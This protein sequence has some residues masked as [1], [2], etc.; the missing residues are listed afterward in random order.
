MYTYGVVVCSRAD[1][2]LLFI[3]LL[4]MCTLGVPLTSE[5]VA[6]VCRNLIGDSMV[7]PQAMEPLEGS[8]LKECD[9]HQIFFVFHHHRGL[10]Y[11]YRTCDTPGVRTLLYGIIVL[12]RRSTSAAPSRFICL[13][14]TP[15]SPSDCYYLLL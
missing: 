8:D 9:H 6:D 2:T 11:M 1:I 13:C 4:A 7:T 15:A 12:L 14:K 3:K 5:L 10:P